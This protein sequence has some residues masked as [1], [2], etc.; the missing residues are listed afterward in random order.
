M[1][2]HTGIELNRRTLAE[3]VSDYLRRELLLSDM[4]EQGTFLREE[5]VAETLGVSRAPVRE[6]MKTLA[7]LGILHLIPRRGVKVVKFTPQEVNE[8]YDVRFA[9]ESLVFDV[10]LQGGLLLPEDYAY[11]EDILSDI[12]KLAESRVTRKEVF[13]LFSNLDLDF[14]L[15]FAKKAK[16]KIIL[17]ILRGVY[18]QL[19]HAMLRD[20]ADSE[21]N[22]VYLVEQHRKML[23]MLRAGNLENLKKNRFYSYFIRRVKQS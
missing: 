14:H 4:W 8:L 16:R 13:W 21:K 2:I 18:A 23:E 3:E 1:T 12:L 6:A 5:D 7:G 15:Y 22:L 17:Q 10:L 19:Q 9:L 11:L 20:W